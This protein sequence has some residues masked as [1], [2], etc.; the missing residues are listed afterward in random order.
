MQNPV[1]SLH[2]LSDRKCKL[3]E[4]LLMIARITKIRKAGN[5]KCWEEN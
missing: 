4:M 2:L 1:K 3:N 5:I